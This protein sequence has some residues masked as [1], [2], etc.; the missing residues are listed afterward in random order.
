MVGLLVCVEIGSLII[1]GGQRQ[2]G[3]E[4]VKILFQMLMFINAG[5]RAGRFRPRA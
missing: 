2:A 5:L 4:K 1:K 3:A